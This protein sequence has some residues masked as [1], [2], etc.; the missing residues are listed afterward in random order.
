[1]SH[2]DSSPTG[3]K[4]IS[5]GARAHLADRVN[6]PIAPWRYAALAVLFSL[7]WASAFI[8]VKVALRDSPPLFMMSSRF[9]VAGGALLALAWLRRV[10]FP[11]NAAAWGRLVL[12]G[13]LNYAI[14]LGL[15]AF[16]LRHLSAGMGA[17]LA[18]T[19][20]LM[21][22]LV[23]PWFLG[24]RLTLGKLAGLLLSFAGVLWVMTSR[25]GDDNRPGAM[26]IMLLAIACLVAGTIV[27]KRS[28][29]DHD[30]LVINGIQ[31]L[32]AGLA[33]VGPSLLTEPLAAVR[34]TPAFL[35]AQAFLVVAVSWVGM[36]IWF[37]LLSHG[38]ATRASA[39]FF[40]NP[41]LGLFL[42]ALLLGEVLGF[43]DFAGS[44]A[45]AVGIYIVQRA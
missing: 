21:L 29:F 8:A 24:E 31:L 17:V 4:P 15:T 7:L 22:A 23:A 45:V 19:N 11:Q 38:D 3:P 10:P 6:A 25:L 18:S 14:Y 41:I 9:L 40:L 32:A 20:P 27:F 37:W 1:M 43:A 44:G 39:Y 35:A 5:N 13:L 34:L 42:G 2:R 28:S 16:A 33:L 26:A 36:L 12:L 30:L